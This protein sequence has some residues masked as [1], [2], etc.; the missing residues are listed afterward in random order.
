MGRGEAGGGLGPGQDTLKAASERLLLSRERR[1]DSW[2]LEERNSFGV[3]DR[4]DCSE[5][6]CNKI[7]LKYKRERKLLTETSEGAERVHLC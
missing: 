5:L 2:P 3:S 4:L 6:L 1:Q 7:L